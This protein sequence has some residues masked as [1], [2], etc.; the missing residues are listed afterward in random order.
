MRIIIT[1][2]SGYFGINLAEAFDNDGYDVVGVDRHRQ[3]APFLESFFH[4]DIHESKCQW[5]EC[6]AIVHLAGGSKVIDKPDDWYINE[7][8]STTQKIRDAYPDTKLVLASST[9]VYSIDEHGVPNT[10]YARAKLAS[11]QLADVVLRFGSICGKNRRGEWFS[12][13]DRMIASALTENAISVWRPRTHRY[14]IDIDV[15]SVFTVAHTAHIKA[16]LV[17]MFQSYAD[18]LDAG[19]AVK[20]CVFAKTQKRI[21]TFNVFDDD[22]DDRNSIHIDQ[23]WDTLLMPRTSA[24]G[25]FQ[26]ICS[27]VDTVF[28]NHYKRDIDDRLSDT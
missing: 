1:G 8:V 18:V 6:N 23:G 15:A 28:T 27:F 21:D 4:E 20:E 24:P 11:E 10:P 25:A 9:A 5:G 22:E 19:R 16:G 7:Q 13:V 2:I 17:D 14:L 26:S 12:L 3:D